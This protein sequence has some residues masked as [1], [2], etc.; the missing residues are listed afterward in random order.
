MSGSVG[1]SGDGW[2]PDDH[3]RSLRSRRGSLGE[4]AV[5]F[6]ILGASFW[7]CQR[8]VDDNLV[9]ASIWSTSLPILYPHAITFVLVTSTVLS[10]PSTVLAVSTF[11]RVDVPMVRYYMV[12]VLFHWIPFQ[13]YNTA[14]FAAHASYTMLG[15]MPLHVTQS[16]VGPTEL[17]QERR[18][19][20]WF[21]S[22][23]S[24]DVGP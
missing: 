7:A 1:V 10:S 14:H 20:R 5:K 6:V 18:Q 13:E 2:A 16:A 21:A 19:K 4:Q 12:G 15:P 3:H 23:H 24:I 17:R 9:Q 22:E 11:E 8:K